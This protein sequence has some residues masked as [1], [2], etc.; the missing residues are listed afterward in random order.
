MLGSDIIVI[1]KMRRVIVIEGF[2]MRLASFSSCSIG[3][4]LISNIGGFLLLIFCFIIGIRP[5]MNVKENKMKV[6]VLSRFIN[7][8]KLSVSIHFSEM[9]GSSLPSYFPFDII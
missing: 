4:L 7:S 3:R 8:L 5:N 2:I 9:H 1:C 6:F